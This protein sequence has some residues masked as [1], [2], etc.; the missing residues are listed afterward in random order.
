MS[1]Q[2]LILAKLYFM[3][4]YCN[5]TLLLYPILLYLPSLCRILNYIF[6]IRERSPNHPRS[7]SV[8]THHAWTCVF[9]TINCLT[10]CTDFSYTLKCLVSCWGHILKQHFATP[11]VLI[12]KITYQFW[13]K[14]AKFYT[15][16]L[17]IM[18]SMA[19]A[20]QSVGLLKGNCK[21]KCLQQQRL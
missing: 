10:C 8:N 16:G 5:C 13:K 14:F 20:C 1:L 15:Q 12:I 17:S 18:K 4:F 2:P 19:K 6:L 11:K 21:Y 7:K 3:R 9:L